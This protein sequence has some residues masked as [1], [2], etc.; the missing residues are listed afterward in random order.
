VLIEK[1]ATIVTCFI[2]S[3]L[4]FDPAIDGDVDPAAP[5]NSMY[6]NQP[7]KRAAGTSGLSLT[8]HTAGRASIL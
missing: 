5:I 3:N 2:D 4:L 6:H 7:E 8:Q 1:P